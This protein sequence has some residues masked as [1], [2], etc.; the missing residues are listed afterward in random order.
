MYAMDLESKQFRYFA[1]H[2]VH[3]WR[4]LAHDA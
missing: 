1:L 2:G 3:S 4:E